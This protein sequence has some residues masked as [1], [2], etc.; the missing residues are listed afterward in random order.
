M[1]RLQ[2][3]HDNPLITV[4]MYARKGNEC[5]ATLD[6]GPGFLLPLRLLLKYRHVVER[7]LG[8]TSFCTR[9]VRIR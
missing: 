7:G 2:S 9:L 5:T 8:S 3:Q 1:A 4:W 6:G